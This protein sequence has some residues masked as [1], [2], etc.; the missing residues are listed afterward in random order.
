[1]DDWLK[2]QQGLSAMSQAP[3]DGTVSFS[4]NGSSVHHPP[5]RQLSLATR[6]LLV[7]LAQEEAMQRARA[8]H[9][10]SALAGSGGAPQFTT[11]AGTAP[12]AIV[13]SSSLKHDTNSYEDSFPLEDSLYGTPSYAGSYGST[14]GPS[15]GFA[16]HQHADFGSTDDQANGQTADTSF[17]YLY[18]AAQGQQQQQFGFGSQF[19]NS[20]ALDD[21]RDNSGLSPAYLNSGDDDS[22]SAYG[23]SNWT[24]SNAG[25]VVGA[26]DAIGLDFDL[27]TMMLGTRSASASPAPFHEQQDSSSSPFLKRRVDANKTLMPSTVPDSARDSDSRSPFKLH[28]TITAS[29][30]T[31]SIGLR[32]PSTRVN[33]PPTLAPLAIPSDGPSFNLIQ[34]TPMTAR[35]TDKQKGAS[36]L[37][38]ERIM[39]LNE[40]QAKDA[41]VSFPEFTPTTNVSQQ[42]QLPLFPG[43]DKFTAAPEPYDASASVAGGRSLTPDVH[44]PAG[45]RPPIRQRSRSEADIRSPT[46]GPSDGSIFDAQLAAAQA[47]AN[48]PVFPSANSNAF[49]QPHP[50]QNVFDQALMQAASAWQQASAGSFVPVQVPDAQTALALSE[51]IR[52]Q[53]LRFLQL[54]QQHAMASAGQS[55]TQPQSNELSFGTDVRAGFANPGMDAALHLVEGHRRSRS[56]GHLHSLP[57]FANTPQHTNELGFLA[58]LA[59]GSRSPSP[60]RSIHSEQSSYSDL[61]QPIDAASFAEQLGIQTNEVPSF[62]AFPIDSTTF[63]VPPPPVHVPFVYHSPH[64]S[65]QGSMSSVNSAGSG[66]GLSPRPPVKS[67]R[68][69]APTRESK[70]TQATIDAA[71][72]RRNPGT[73]AKFVCD[74]CGETFT[75]R[76]NLKGHLRAHRNEKPFICSYDGCDKAFARSHDCKRHELL[77]LN[78]RRY[79]CE[80]CK[81]DFVRLDALQRHHRSEIGQ[82]CVEQLRLQG[83]T[84]PYDTAAPQVAL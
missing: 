2:Q 64:Q 30:P 84:I 6:D 14:H 10:S 49:P 12:V 38:L 72:R 16:H 35:P 23:D 18:K 34:P 3:Q 68:N 47:Q 70:T 32:P 58:P 61:M 51:Q 67:R 45:S 83:F 37:E 11:S 28:S 69:Q 5:P 33:S 55:R 9:D 42:A 73:N 63:D 76:Y 39:G 44:G 59:Q 4:S 50:P 21:Y 46:S 52:N 15:T 57:H 81:R 25:S 65:R 41:T 71:M 36:T 66:S 1:M 77:H 40:W 75:R 26:E 56:Q 29:P 17:D 79:H 78:V 13:D 82:Q 27:E 7:S 80:P 43:K 62:P 24:S 8:M 74:L 53:Q 20:G 60:T 19:G 54:Q 48:L 22:S 31:S